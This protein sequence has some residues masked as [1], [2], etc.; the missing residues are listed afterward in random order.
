MFTKIKGAIA[1]FKAGR[2]ERR[3]EEKRQEALRGETTSGHA[4]PG[5]RDRMM[6]Q[7]KEANEAAERRRGRR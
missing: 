6:R 5:D 4:T 2:E 7:A 3:A 1:A